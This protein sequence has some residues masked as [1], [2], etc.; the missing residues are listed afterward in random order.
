MD[1][2][3]LKTKNNTLVTGVTKELLD[4]TQQA[5][6]IK[7]PE[8]LSAFLRF[9]DGCII[10]G[11]VIFFSCGQGV[12]ASERILNFNSPDSVKLFLRI[13]RFSEDEFGYKN[14]DLEDTDPAVYVLD[15]ETDEVE[16][17]AS[18]LMEFLEKYSQEQPPKK[19]KWYSFLFS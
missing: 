13:G 14:S 10:N 16:K 17:L 15:H 4:E 18:N 8:T 3:F 2:T 9:S 19:K 6:K 5:L 12:E 1:F 7:I 11:R